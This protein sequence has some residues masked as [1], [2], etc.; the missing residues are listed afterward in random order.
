MKLKGYFILIV[1]LSSFIA[2]TSCK[3]DEE[4]EKPSLEGTWEYSNIKYIFTKTNMTQQLEINNEWETVEEATYK[5]DADKNLITTTILKTSFEGSD[6]LDELPYTLGG[7]TYKSIIEEQSIAF[8]E[9][10]NLTIM[11]IGAYF[12]GNTET[13][14]GE[15]VSIYKTTYEIESGGL[16]NT[17]SSDMNSSLKFTENTVS[18]S[19]KAIDNQTGGLVNKQETAS[20]SLDA[21]NTITISGASANNFTLIDGKYKYKIIGKGLVISPAPGYEAVYLTKQ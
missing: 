11:M 19:Y 5:Y 8:H 21:N 15:W 10:E 16:T 6:A 13:L 2:L 4:E 17:I 12:G 7:N 3:K 9:G 18:I 20:W 1:I 14:I